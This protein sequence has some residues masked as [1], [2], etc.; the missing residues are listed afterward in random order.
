MNGILVLIREFYLLL[1]TFLLF[2]FQS[3]LTLVLKY[4]SIK[5]LKLNFLILKRSNII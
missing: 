4:K 3:W 2:D 1:Y 5:K